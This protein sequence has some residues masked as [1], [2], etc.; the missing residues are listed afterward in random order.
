[1][2]LEKIINQILASRTDI[3]RKKIL[4]MIENKKKETGNFLTDESAAR[5]AAS[6][7]GVK[8]AKKPTHLKIQIKDLVSGLNDVSLTGQVISVFPP[9]RFKRRDWTEGKIANLIISDRSGTLRVVLWDNKADL[10]LTKKIQREETIKISHGYVREGR[11]G[12]LEL[13]LGDR[14]NIRITESTKR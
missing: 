10:V 13:H 7:L 4:K 5:I 8:I 12:K 1:M 6:E 9:K 14:G 11:D 2:G 3:K